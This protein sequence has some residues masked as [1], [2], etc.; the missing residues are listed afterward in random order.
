MN[1]LAKEVPQ[2][3]SRY[4]PGLFSR[5]IEELLARLGI[6]MRQSQIFLAVEGVAAD[7]L[8]QLRLELRRDTFRDERST[9]MQCHAP[10]ARTSLIGVRILSLEDL[11]FYPILS[12]PL[13]SARER[14]RSSNWIPA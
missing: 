7:A 5:H 13:D 2:L 1:V 11:A 10:F 12:S 14:D 3:L 8:V 6:V 4:P 9:P